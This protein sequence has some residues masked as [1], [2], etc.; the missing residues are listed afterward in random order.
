M[1][2]TPQHRQ[3]LLEDTGKLGRVGR[4]LKGPTPSSAGSSPKTRR[5]LIYRL[6]F[7]WKI[8][9]MI[10]FHACVPQRPNKRKHLWFS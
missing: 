4:D 1:E 7:P 9:L 3:Q 8:K 5:A 10:D 2:A 6:K